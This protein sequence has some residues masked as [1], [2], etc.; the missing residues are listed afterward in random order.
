MLE[1]RARRTGLDAAAARRAARLAL[2]GEAQIADAWHDQR[3][4]PFLDTL[5]QDLRYGVRVLRRSPGFTATAVLTLALGIGANTAIFTVVDT[6]LLRPLPFADPDRLM[7]VGDR[8][9]DGSSANAGFQ[10]MT[11]WRDRSRTLE[12]F[13]G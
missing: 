11:L 13:A 3:G 7:T 1:E 6:V 10:T 9:P 12:G 4:L 2:G 5:R 8:N